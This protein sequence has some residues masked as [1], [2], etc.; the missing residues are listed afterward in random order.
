MSKCDR[1][2]TLLPVFLL[3][4]RSIRDRKKGLN[5]IISEYER[6]KHKR[7]RC[8]HARNAEY[9]CAN[10]ALKSLLKSGFLRYFKTCVRFHFTADRRRC[11]IPRISQNCGHIMRCKF[12]SRVSLRKPYRSFVNYIFKS[13]LR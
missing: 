4:L 8:I 9:R 5:K 10:C 7:I 12:V 2:C 13:S 11:F 1:F 3:I 6:G